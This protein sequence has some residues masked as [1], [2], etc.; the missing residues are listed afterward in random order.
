MQR[1]FTTGKFSPFVL[2]ALLTLGHSQA[3]A[4]LIDSSET[5]QSL[6]TAFFMTTDSG[7]V[8]GPEIIGDDR[9]AVVTWKS[10]PVFS[11]FDV[12]SA[13]TGFLSF[14]LGADTNGSTALTWD[15]NDSSSA[16]D[17]IGLGGVDLTD[18][19]MSNA[20]RFDVVFD[21]LPVDVNITVWTDAS[22]TS[23][24]ILSLPGRITSSLRQSFLFPLGPS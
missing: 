8:I 20:M 19:N 21:D 14:S 17:F 12:V 24:A 3:Q 16:D 18:D 15:G 9:D 23:N 13:G 10:G 11:E 6:M 22:N 2:L 5:S 1:R 7:S 4:E